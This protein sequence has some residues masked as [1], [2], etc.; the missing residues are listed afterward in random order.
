[1]LPP[2]L[3]STNYHGHTATNPMLFKLPTGRIVEKDANYCVA[4]KCNGRWSHKFYKQA[5]AAINEI[6]Y[7]RECTDATKAYYGIEES[8][9][10]KGNPA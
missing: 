5:R 10:I 7:A 4:V 1:M 9:M 8:R 3:H 2:N 6:S